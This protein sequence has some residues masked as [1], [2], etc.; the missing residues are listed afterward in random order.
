MKRLVLLVIGSVM[1]LGCGRKESEEISVKETKYIPSVECPTCDSP[2]PEEPIY[3][4][5]PGPKGDAGDDGS[6]GS[7]GR[8]G[9]DG[10]DSRD[11]RDGRDG[12]DSR[13][14]R[15]GRDGLTPVPQPYPIPSQPYP[16]R[17]CEDCNYNP[18]CCDRVKNVNV[19]I[20]KN[21][22]D[23]RNSNDVDFVNTDCE[24]KKPNTEWCDCV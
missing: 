2:E 23:N 6:D 16:C 12:R 3:I 17:W 10:R 14:G 5:V 21:L 7:D 4:P 8:D 22:N 18:R 15:D 20:N 24:F 19:N 1:I 13:D 9:R 11:G